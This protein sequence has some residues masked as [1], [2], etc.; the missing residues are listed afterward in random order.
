MRNLVTASLEREDS[1]R[2]TFGWNVSWQLVAVFYQELMLVIQRQLS[3]VIMME[4]DPS[5]RYTAN[6]Q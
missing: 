5:F 6:V 3:P 4:N 1:P 2:H